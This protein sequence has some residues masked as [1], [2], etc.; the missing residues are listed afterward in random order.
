M[1]NPCLQCLVRACCSEVCLDKR[2]FV[3]L[4]LRDLTTFTDHY[5]YDEKNQRLSDLD[6]SLDAEHNRLLAICEANQG[7]VSLIMTRGIS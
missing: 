6:P 4:C 5:L 2:K 1:K 3:D 7:E